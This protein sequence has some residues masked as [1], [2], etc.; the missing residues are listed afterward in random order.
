[1]NIVG[2]GTDIVDVSRINRLIVHGDRRFLDRWLSPAEVQSCLAQRSAARHT[3]GLFAAK[4]AV[5]KSLR[6]PESGPLPWRDIEITHSSGELPGV[7]LHG[8]MSQ[9]ATTAGAA[10]FTVSITHHPRYALATVVAVSQEASL[11]L[12]G[13]DLVDLT[14]KIARLHE[15]GLRAEG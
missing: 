12:T 1:M 10:R 8:A 9:L 2:V 6:R 11:R 4:E 3:A 5:F 15:V 7:R 13:G 14:E